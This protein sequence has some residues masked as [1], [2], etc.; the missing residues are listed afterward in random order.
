MSVRPHIAAR[1]LAAPWLA[2]VLCLV[3][4]G[5]AGHS[6]EDTAD[7][8]LRD[9]SCD[10][11]PD[12]IDLHNGVIVRAVG[13]SVLQVRVEGNV[14][15]SIPLPA[16]D[17]AGAFSF[18]S[19]FPVIDAL[20][21][22]ETARP[23]RAVW[24]PL[25]PYELFLNPLE[26][27][28]GTELL[29]SRLK[30]GLVVPLESRRYSW[31]V[32]NDN[33]PW[34]LAAS[35]VYKAG[36]SRRWLRTLADVSANVVGEDCT[37]A[38]NPSTGLFYGI[39]RY[40]AAFD[41][42]FP[43]WMDA[44]DVFRVQSLA[45]NVL[46]WAVLRNLDGITRDMAR[47]NERSGLPQL[48]VDADSL[49]HAVNLEM[50]M[51]NIGSYS[52]LLYGCSLCPLQLHGTDDIAGAMAV[53][54]GF[55]S[56]PMAASVIRNSALPRSGVAQALWAPA[57]A[58]AGNAAAYDAACG[59]VLS[60]AAS[61][62]LSSVPAAAP[63]LANPLTGLLLRGFLGMRFAFDGIYFAPSV[64]RGL[65]GVKRI[66]GL[67]YRRGILD[68]NL[69]GTG[70]AIVSFAIDGKPAE[71]FFPAAAASG[72][73]VVDIVLAGNPLPQGTVG[74]A[75]D[76]TLPSPPVVEWNNG[77]EAT[78]LPAAAAGSGRH[79][80]LAASYATFVCLNGV[81]TEEVLSH[82]YH[83]YDAASP[84][85]VQFVSVEDN[86]LMG[87]SSRP[88][89]Y[90]PPG[91]ETRVELAD[92][93]RGGTKVIENRRLAER[94]I[95]S[96]RRRNRNVR[97]DYTAPADGDYIVDVHY[98][99]GLGIVN[100]RRRTALRALYVDGSRRG[101]FVFP[102]HSGA[103]LDRDGG[104]DWQTL[105][106]FSNPLRI[107]LHKGLNHMELRLYQPSPVYIDPTANTLLADF[108]RIIPLGNSSTSKTSLTSLPSTIGHLTYI[109]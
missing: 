85:V 34:L 61:G 48:P 89:L 56:A 58:M 109:P 86:K 73:H 59:A 96:D 80:G 108:I 82:T 104:Y 25:V 37:V 11:W 69:S 92:V 64:P 72:R 51:P 35:E 95:E 6:R 26:V 19:D 23:R 16:H 99:S 28:Y 4:Q 46:Y 14:L 43:A 91:E 52:P 7:R 97:F 78:I 90:V 40:M 24:H 31:P 87:F 74:S 1:A 17:A 45:V 47:R 83:L 63:Q 60:S 33:A 3:L 100:A 68:I 53:L 77:R 39:P 27:S 76:A 13:D 21:R 106:S 22:L 20:L 44:S 42:R 62:L 79:D 5:C 75:V 29:E 12:S 57:A 10:I 66:S 70:N 98:I 103:S 71:P 67:R 54:T 81:L 93:A 94:F 101:I 8:V 88:H 9:D 2:M 55:A 105:T 41:A 102:Q 107:R 36:G 18:Q 30:N 38:R 15:R 84:V 65:P 32:V 49:R 50:W